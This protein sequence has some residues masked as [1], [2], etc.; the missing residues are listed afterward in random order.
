MCILV[1]EELMCIGYITNS[2]SESEVEFL[3]LLVFLSPFYSFNESGNEILVFSKKK[4]MN[5][6][7]KFHCHFRGSCEEEVLLEFFSVKKI[8]YFVQV[9]FDF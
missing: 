1:L 7:R 4:N 9:Y 2:L 8:F 6:N 3:N 5:S